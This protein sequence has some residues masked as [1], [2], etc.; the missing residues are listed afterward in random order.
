MAK[1]V[2]TC[3][4]LSICVIKN[5]T[6]KLCLTTW[7]VLQLIHYALKANKDINYTFFAAINKLACVH[8]FSSNERFGSKLISVRISKHHSCK[9]CSTTWVVNYFLKEMKYQSQHD[10]F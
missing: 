8:P 2:Y 1:N 3:S 9:W 4:D 6:Y 10:A 7:V 5:W